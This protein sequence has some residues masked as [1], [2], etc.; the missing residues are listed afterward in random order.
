MASIIKP[1]FWSPGRNP[2]ALNLW[3]GNVLYLPMWEMAGGRVHDLSGH[4]HDGVL[5]NMDPA[6]D[7]ISGQHGPALAFDGDN[8][9]VETPPVVLPGPF[10]VSEM[11]CYRTTH[12][13]ETNM[14]GND[15]H[16]W[17]LNGSGAWGNTH[18]VN[19]IFYLYH[20]D[21]ADG[22]SSFY[23]SNAK[24]TDG[25]WHVIVTVVDLATNTYAV[26][27]DGEPQSLTAYHADPATAWVYFKVQLGGDTEGYGGWFPGY[28]D[29]D[30]AAYG[31]W[32]R[33][34]TQADAIRLSA[35]PFCMIREPQWKFFGATDG[36]APPAGQPAMRR[37]EHVPYMPHTY[38]L[39]SN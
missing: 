23:W 35:D 39:R 19:S 31:M 28:V 26:Y 33:L 32:N 6:T 34:L 2:D 5:K 15:G 37:W 3:R 18:T 20:S 38:A 13:A 4:G 30:I 25:N 27:V 12:Q 8:D 16:V 10:H 22:R 17:R 11:L 9:Y 21:V 24:H 1:P 36:G 29:M 14:I 7:W